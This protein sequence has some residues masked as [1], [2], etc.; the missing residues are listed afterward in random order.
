MK[1]LLSSSSLKLRTKPLGLK[2]GFLFLVAFASFP[3]GWSLAVASQFSSV[4]QSC[5]TL[6]DPMNRSTPGLPVHHH[7]PEFTQTHV[8]RVRDAIQPSHPGL[9][10]SPPA[11]SPSQNQS[12][13]TQRKMGNS[14]F[15]V[16][17]GIGRARTIFQVNNLLRDLSH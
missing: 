3:F 2:G 8:H 15:F 13:H 6:C 11:P 16:R 1:A 9:S 12:L 5:P 17:L 4:A 10:P 14:Y 7:L